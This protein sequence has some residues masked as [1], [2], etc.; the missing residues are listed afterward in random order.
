MFQDHLSKIDGAEKLPQTLFNQ[1]MGLNLRGELPRYPNE[2]F[3]VTDSKAVSVTKRNSMGYRCDEFPKD[4]APKPKILFSGCSITYGSGLNINDTWAKKVYDELSVKYDLGPYINIARSGNSV[5]GI[6]ADI[7]KYINE[8]GKP[9]VVALSFPSIFR[10]YRIEQNKDGYSLYNSHLPLYFNYS[11]EELKPIIDGLIA[12]VVDYIMMLD[13]FCRSNDIALKMFV[14][15]GTFKNETYGMSQYVMGLL[16]HVQDIDLELYKLNAN[17]QDGHKT[18]GLFAN[19][20]HL[21]V[22]YH[23]IFKNLMLGPIEGGLK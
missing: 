21:G 18:K 14:W 15:D 3:E 10:G 4:G 7:F 5:F 16:E 19:D 12:Y 1:G 20:N 11:L 17:A 23:E 8:Y 6:I 9:D 22:L 2:T 13:I